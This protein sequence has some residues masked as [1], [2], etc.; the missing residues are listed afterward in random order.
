MAVMSQNFE[1]QSLGKS[2]AIFA[3]SF[4]FGI[5]GM[6][7]TGWLF[8]TMNWPYFHTWALAHGSSPICFL[9]W[10]FIGYHSAK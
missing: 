1:D 6:M 10:A 8:N 2:V 3:I 4:S 5:A 7:A 9:F